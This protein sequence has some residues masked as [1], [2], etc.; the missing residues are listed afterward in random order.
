MTATWQDDVVHRFMFT[1]AS[2][3]WRKS[4]RRSLWFRFLNRLF[5]VRIPDAL[6]VQEYSDADWTTGGVRGSLVGTWVLDGEGFRTAE[7]PATDEVSHSR[8]ERLI[9]CSSDDAAAMVHYYSPFGG[10]GHVMHV[11]T[12]DG[13]QTLRTTKSWIF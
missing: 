6:Y 1:E 12:Q 7:A 13:R 3:L 4:Q 5:R 11:Q 10:F 9:F 8:F 2:E